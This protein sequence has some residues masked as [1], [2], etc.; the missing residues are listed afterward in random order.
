[1]I[2]AQAVKIYPILI[3]ALTNAATGTLGQFDCFGHNYARIDL[4]LSATNSVTN[5]PTVAK[6]QSADVT[7]T[8]SFADITG[9]SMTSAF[10]NGLTTTTLT[11]VLS[12]NVDLRAQKRYLRV[13]ISPLTS[14]T[15]A[16]I[17]TLSRSSQAEIPTAAS[18][19]A[20]A[21]LVL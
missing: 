18:C 10:T 14:Q 4:C 16:G 9:G 1:M 19:N 6:I 12:W 21:L 17:V 20:S 15:V 5:V 11:D 3:T 8:S 13:L 7:N 2:S